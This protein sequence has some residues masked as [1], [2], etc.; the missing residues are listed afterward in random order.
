MYKLWSKTWQWAYRENTFQTRAIIRFTIFLTTAHKYS[1]L[2]Q[3]Y[4][5]PRERLLFPKDR[6]RDRD[7]TYLPLQGHFSWHRS[8]RNI[9]SGARASAR[10]GLR[11]SPTTSRC[12]HAKSRKILC[13]SRRFPAG[14][15]PGTGHTCNHRLAKQ[16]LCLLNPRQYRYLPPQRPQHKTP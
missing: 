14:L 9:D 4:A 10:A 3:Q 12:N 2:G 8:T 6:D 13:N 5:R 1:W 15:C 16:S 7:T 11:H